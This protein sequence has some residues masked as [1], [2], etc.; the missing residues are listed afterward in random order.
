M[1][2]WILREHLLWT[3]F[4][5][6]LHQPRWQKAMTLC[7]E[8]RISFFCVYLIY[9][10]CSYFFCQWPRVRGGK[11]LALIHINWSLLRKWVFNFSLV[12]VRDIFYIILFGRHKNNSRRLSFYK[13]PVLMIYFAAIHKL[14][15]VAKLFHI[16]VKTI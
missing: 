16:C 15:P 13:I 12:R 3:S 8:K 1:T 5:F 7:C 2:H 11:R 9:N 6:D 10:S 4:C 14:Q